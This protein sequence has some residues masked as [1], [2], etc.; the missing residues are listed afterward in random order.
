MEK[1]MKSRFKLLCLLVVSLWS[2]QIYAGFNLPIATANSGNNTTSGGGLGTSSGRFEQSGE[3]NCLEKEDDQSVSP[4]FLSAVLGMGQPIKFKSFPNHLYDLSF[5]NFLDVKKCFSPVTIVEAYNNNKIIRLKNGVNLGLN[6]LDYSN[7]EGEKKKATAK[8]IE[9][10]ADK[11]YEGE[12]PEANDVTSSNFQKYSSWLTNLSQ[13]DKIKRCMA[14]HYPKLFKE[15]GNSFVAN[16][17]EWQRKS[18]PWKLEGDSLEVP[19]NKTKTS[20]YFFS[21]PNYSIYNNSSYKK[22]A[23]DN[24]YALP[25]N[26]AACFNIVKINNKKNYAVKTKTDGGNDKLK[27]GCEE[28]DP[29]LYMQGI[30]KL[31]GAGNASSLINTYNSVL[32]EM[33]KKDTK[34]MEKESK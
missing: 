33:L 12:I 18:R 14:I 16:A 15:E 25:E 34:K 30:A 26:N 4:A 9:L 21:S 22:I 10:F 11:V 28:Q 2:G 32:Y 20:K 19:I 5:P 8:R 29:L 31:E 6:K 17:S 1:N 7:Q 23:G 3:N 13:E 24:K 27:S